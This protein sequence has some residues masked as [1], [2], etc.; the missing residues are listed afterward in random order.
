M[1]KIVRLTESDLTK[2]VQRVLNEQDSEKI[3]AQLLNLDGK[4]VS[5]LDLSDG[6]MYGSKVR[7]Y[8]Y[9]AGR[10]G[11]MDLLF[12]C[13]SKKVNVSGKGISLPSG[14]TYKFTDKTSK[15][16]VDKFC[17]AYSSTGNNV[18]TSSYT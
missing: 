16:I 18:D 5:N 6:R 11:H 2:I 12:D 8:A 14:Q 9:E 13:G 4:L 15:N 7:F 17:S 1:K 3:K 10:S